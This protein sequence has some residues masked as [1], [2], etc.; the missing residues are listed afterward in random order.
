ME[1]KA[2]IGMV[3]DEIADLPEE[4]AT[5]NQVSV[6]KFKI[7]YQ[8]LENL[9]GNI[10]QKIREGERRGIKSLVK[11]SQPSINDF[12]RAFKEKLAQFEEVI[13]LT[14]SSKISGAYNS[15]VQARKFLSQE[16]Q[17]KV[18]I[19]D[20]LTGTGAEGLVALKAIEL[21]RK[22]MHL[23]EII[24]QIKET[25]KHVRLFAM[26]K[27]AKWLEAS[28]RIPHFLIDQAEKRNIKPFFKIAAGRLI[29]G[30]V[31]KNAENLSSALFE[32]FKKATEKIRAKGGKIIVA[33]THADDKEEAEKLEAM[34]CALPGVEIA[35][36][37]LVC[38]TVG[39]HTGPGTMVISWNQQP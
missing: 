33:I 1:L 27:Q 23:D 35:F 14:F 4:T 28:G 13:C 9:P 10:Y 2:K 32:E 22:N 12:L 18:H 16:L 26:Y 36:T 5:A 34:V 38:F 21:I 29:I 15:A 25:V 37:N 31:K 7:D 24:S 17:N 20:T 3:V 6:V 8:D 19:I 30:G 11:T 39:G